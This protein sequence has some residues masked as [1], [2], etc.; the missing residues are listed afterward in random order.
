MKI[1]IIFTF[2]GENKLSLI[3]MLFKVA[4]PPITKNFYI[5]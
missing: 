5:V 2:E 4:T 1:I 3:S